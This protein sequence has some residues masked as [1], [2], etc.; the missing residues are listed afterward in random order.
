MKYLSV[1]SAGK[2]A[3]QILMMTVLAA[4]SA[5]AAEHGETGFRFNNGRLSGAANL[6]ISMQEARLQ[7]KEVV[8]YSDQWTHKIVVFIYPPGSKTVWLWD[9]Q[10]SAHELKAEF[11]D[12]L[13]IARAWGAIEVPGVPILGAT[14]GLSTGPY[15]PHCLPETPVC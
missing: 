12:A 2:F 5:P 6:I 13:A 15:V 3:L 10:S 11:N 9:P 7:A 8:V 14:F 4:G 1:S